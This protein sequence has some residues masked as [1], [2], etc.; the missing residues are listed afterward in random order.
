MARMLRSALPGYV[1][2]WEDCS[3]KYVQTVA[4]EIEGVEKAEKDCLLVENEMYR[5][6]EYDGSTFRVATKSALLRQCLKNPYREGCLWVIV[7]I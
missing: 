2:A 5:F 7:E 4:A 3:E 1:G 6:V